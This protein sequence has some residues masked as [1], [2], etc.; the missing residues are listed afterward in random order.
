MTNPEQFQKELND[1]AQPQESCGE[2]PTQKFLNDILHPGRNADSTAAQ[3]GSDPTAQNGSDPTE[4]RR[5]DA[6][7]RPHNNSDNQ[8]QDPM[9]EK[10]GN[11][12]SLKLPADFSK[13]SSDKEANFIQF[14]SNAQKDTRVSYWR[15]GDFSADDEDS[16][17]IDDVMKKAPHTL[18][19]QETLD[20][21]PLMA[22]GKPW[23]TG[24]YRDLTLR[25]T[26]IDGRRVLVAD[27][28][29][30]EQDKQVRLIIANQNKD[31]HEI[32]NIWLEGPCKDFDKSNKATI[33]AIHQLK[34][35]DKR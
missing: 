14:Q 6:M 5:G 24:N 35:T 20:V 3:N 31:S 4:K 23:G 33:D 1:T 17:L 18:D 15:R 9:I 21:M 2:C 27:F 29:S 13:G 10:Q 19:E 34:W 8:K 11:V 26:D 28:K 30:N 22:P 32:E 12:E 25:T 16:K 7:R